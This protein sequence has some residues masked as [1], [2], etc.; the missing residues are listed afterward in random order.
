M[1]VGRTAP[2]RWQRN[3]G[4][5]NDDVR[6]FVAQQIG[7]LERRVPGAIALAVQM[8]QSKPTAQVAMAF[9]TVAVVNTSGTVDVL[10]DGE[11]TPVEMPTSAAVSATDRVRILFVPPAGAVVLGTV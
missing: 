10:L 5:V 9:G 11:D 2:S 8:A 3:V 1:R 6:Q 7:E 4:T